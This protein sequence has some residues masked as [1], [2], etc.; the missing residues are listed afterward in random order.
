MVIVT[1]FNSNASDIYRILLIRGVPIAKG[2]IKIWLSGKKLKGGYALTRIKQGK[3]QSWL[4]IKMDDELADARRNR[5]STEPES[6]LS[7][8]TLSEIK[9][10]G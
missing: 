10:Q 2:H 4:L 3:N 5:V 8:K 7:G 9:A 6:V 1:A